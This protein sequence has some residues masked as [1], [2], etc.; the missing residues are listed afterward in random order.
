[1]SRQVTRTAKP[2]YVSARPDHWTVPRP[3]T[4]ASLR[5]QKH[6]PV[7]S[8]PDE[9][10]DWFHIGIRTFCVALGVIGAAHAFGYSILS[11]VGI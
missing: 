1:M 6:G 10:T 5:F 11:F 2:R 3:H 9:P 7:Q 8:M 4:D